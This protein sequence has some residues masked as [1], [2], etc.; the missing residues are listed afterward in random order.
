MHIIAGKAVCAEEALTQEFKQYIFQ[1]LYNT[2]IMCNEFKAM[3]YK[4]I[5]DGTDNHLFLIDLT[6]NFPNLTGREVQ[7]EL[8]KHKITLNKNCVPNEKRSPMEASGLRIGCAAMTTKGWNAIQFIAVAHSI[9]K[10]IRELDQRK[11]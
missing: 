2:W 3:G 1:V 8:D 9:D 5:T 10:I 7:E 4:V 6:K 11:I